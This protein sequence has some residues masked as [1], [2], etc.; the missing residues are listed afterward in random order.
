MQAKKSI[1][2]QVFHKVWK[3]R[4]KF[5]FPIFFYLFQI[6]LSIYL[7]TYN[8]RT[9]CW[10]YVYDYVHIIMYLVSWEIRQPFETD[11]L[12]SMRTIIVESNLFCV[13]YLHNDLCI[14]LFS[15]NITLHY[16][17]IICRHRIE[18]YRLKL[19]SFSFDKTPM[20]GEKSEIKYKIK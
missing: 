13:L 18:T 1:K 4:E 6:Y 17:I 2:F 14:Y 19:R 15:I 12:I 3:N 9:I 20:N 16:S 11:I 5:E 8:I 7:D 10:I